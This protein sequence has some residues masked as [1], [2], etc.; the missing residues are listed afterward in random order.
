MGSLIAALASYLDARA[1]HGRWLLRM[2]DLDPPREPPGASDTILRQLDALRLHWDGEVLYQSQRH[3]AYQEA[4]ASLESMDHIFYC[5][6]SRKRLRELHAV[7]DGHCRLR[8]EPVAVKTAVRLQVAPLSLGF[9]DRIQGWFQQQLDTE[10]GDFVI[11]RKDGLFAYQ[12]AVVVDDAFQKITDIV[13]GYDLLDSTPRQLY[14]QRLLEYPTP[15][16]AH[17]PI[18]VNSRGQK[19][20]KQRFAAA[21]DVDDGPQ[22]LLE[23]LRFLG[24]R[25]PSD[26]RGADCA[27]LLDWATENWDIQAVPKLANIPEITS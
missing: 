10:V 2:E 25:P 11:K 3:G 7:Y 4:L 1:N 22:L 9:D 27:T 19:L 13:R 14:L 26:L 20:S 6:C 18:I 12:L 8:R 16:Y 23:A 15:R 5:R 17:I 21:I 24:Q